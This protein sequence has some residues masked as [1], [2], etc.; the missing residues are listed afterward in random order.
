MFAPVM[1]TLSLHLENA[2]DASVLPIQCEKEQDRL[3]I[4]FVL[5]RRMMQQ[6]SEKPLAAR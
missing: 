6:R 1:S 3:Y 2:N 5:C 4:F